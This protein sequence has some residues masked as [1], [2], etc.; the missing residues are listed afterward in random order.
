MRDLLCTLIVL[1]FVCGCGEEPSTKKDIGSQVEALIEKLAISEEPAGKK[2]I[3]SPDRDTPKTDKRVIAYEA[4]CELKKHGKRAFPFLLRH[5]DD[6]RQSVAFRRV[7]PHDVG[8][9]CFCIIRDQVFCL[10]KDYRGSIY[11]TGGDGKMH[12]R[13][14]FSAPDLFTYK[15]IGP[16]LEARKGKSLEAMQV[17]ALEWLIEQEKRIGFQDEEAKKKFLYPLERQLAVLRKKG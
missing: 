11:R 13:A 15:T 2:P 7:I 12:E 4:A 9:A 5:L 6:K 8:D 1:P 3:Y 10:P 16:W 14:Y 17:E